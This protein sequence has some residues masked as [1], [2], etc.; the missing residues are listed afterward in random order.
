[1]GGGGVG[2]EVLRVV[3][4]H[5][6]V[7]L[8]GLAKTVAH[9]FNRDFRDRS[10][11]PRPRFFVAESLFRPRLGPGCATPG[12]RH[13]PGTSPGSSGGLGMRRSLPPR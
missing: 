5:G 11:P 3:A 4:V 7:S 8:H 6:R 13:D 9:A 2:Q 1:M 10:A 12:G